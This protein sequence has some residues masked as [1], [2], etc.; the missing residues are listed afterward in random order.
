MSSLHFTGSMR[1]ADRGYTIQFALL[2]SIPALIVMLIYDVIAI[3]SGI[4]AISFLTVLIY[5]LSMVA[6]Y[7]GGKLAISTVRSLAVR[8][9]FAGFAYYCWGMALICIILY[10]T[11]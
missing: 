8:N 9:G 2:L 4:E 6:A 5:L 11:T 7:F 10:L 3:F 1:G